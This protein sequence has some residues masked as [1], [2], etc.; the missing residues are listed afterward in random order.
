MRTVVFFHIMIPIAMD[1]KFRTAISAIGSSI[2]KLVVVIRCVG[3]SAPLSE[4][5]K[6]QATS[7]PRD[8]DCESLS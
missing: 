4:D 6:G 8:G 2:R 7:K 3:L 5:G 1:R